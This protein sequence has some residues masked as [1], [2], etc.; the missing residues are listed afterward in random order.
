MIEKYEIL[1]RYPDIEI[2]ISICIFDLLALSVS[3][4]CS[5]LPRF[6]FNN[7]KYFENKNM[8]LQAN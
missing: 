1:L 8:K 2:Y 4:L 6:S 7:K 3:L 5:N